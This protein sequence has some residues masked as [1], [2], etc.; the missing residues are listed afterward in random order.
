MPRLPLPLAQILDLTRVPRR[1]VEASL[2]GSS[3]KP[4]L[5]ESLH[6]VLAALPREVVR[7]RGLE[8]LRVDKHNRLLTVTRPMLCLLGR[9]DRLIRKKYLD[10]LTASRPNCEVRIFDA[11]HMLPETHAAE[12]AIAIHHFCDRVVKSRHGSGLPVRIDRYAYAHWR[13]TRN[14]RFPPSGRSQAFRREG[15][16]GVKR[17]QRSSA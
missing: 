1:I 7:A 8:V 15:L 4:D 5:I 3:R 2:L 10:E 9:Y 14:I 17:G 11:P 16:R 6:R 12:A 13:R